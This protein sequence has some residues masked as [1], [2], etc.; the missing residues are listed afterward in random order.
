MNREAVKILCRQYVEYLSLLIAH[1]WDLDLEDGTGSD[2][3][4]LRDRHDGKRRR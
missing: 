1:H 3:D 2:D 4:S